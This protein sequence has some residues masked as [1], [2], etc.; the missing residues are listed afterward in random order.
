MSTFRNQQLSTQ[1]GIIRLQYKPVKDLFKFS[2]PP[3]VAIGATK[4][5]KT[6]LCL[7]IIAQHAHEATNIY[8]FTQT[9]QKLGSQGGGLDIVPEAYRREPTYENFVA[10]YN[11]IVDINKGI[12]SKTEKFVQV[13]IELT[14]NESSVAKI[15]QIIEEDANSIGEERLAY[16]QSTKKFN[17]EKASEYAKA[18]MESFKYETLSRI[19]MDYATQHREKIQSL[20]RETMTLFQT[21]YS[22][23]PKT[24]LVMDDVTAALNELQRDKSKVIFNGQPTTKYNAFAAILLDLLVR[25]RHFNAIICIF[26][27]SL[28]VLDEA[29][30]NLINLIIVEPSVI[31]QLTNIRSLNKAAVTALQ[32]AA[33]LVFTN[34]YKYH[35]MHVCC[36]ETTD[37]I[38]VTVTKADLHGALE[39][40][41]LNDM[42]KRFIDV[43]NKIKSGLITNGTIYNTNKASDNES[44]EVEVNSSDTEDADDE[45]DSSSVAGDDII[46][47]I[48]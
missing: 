20:S 24:I 28:N 41:K 45:G 38:D 25:G 39:K 48:V 14:G 22:K 4:G 13:L 10:V 12:E 11:E 33:P 21:L 42:N 36:S 15:M 47:N 6:T 5:G 7:D 35:V 18:D 30:K 17:I 9:S 16:Y 32:T 43:Y 26:L 44:S 23:R 40:L 46:M 31:Q 29:K 1:N 3:Y 27:H 8:Y 37:T 34:E 2:E 19:I